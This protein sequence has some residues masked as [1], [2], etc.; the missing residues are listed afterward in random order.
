MTHAYWPLF[1][2]E[3][4]TPR[5]TLRYL[6]DELATELITLASRG[7]HEPGYTPF[8]VPWTDLEPPEFER[9]A[10]DFYWRN[11]HVEAGSWNVLFAV[12][13][14]G[15]VVGSTD[16]GAKDFPVRRWFETGSWLGL[17]HQ[18]QGLGTEVRTATLQFGFLGLDVLMAGTAAFDD[19]AASLAVTRKLGY[20]SNGIDHHRRRDELGIVHKYRMP[21]AHFLA[22]VARDDIEIVGDEAVR[23]LLGIAR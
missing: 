3:V 4:R 10:L 15:E 9:S 20:E 13:H 1:D 2:L 7:V 23:D 18:G 14:D 16:I 11:R 12:L 8:G 22:H 17:E 19:N 5:V 21:R 6:D